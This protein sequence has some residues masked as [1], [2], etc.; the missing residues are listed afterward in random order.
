MQKTTILFTLLVLSVV[1]AGCSPGKKLTTPEKKDAINTM[2][3][4]TL[5][6]L[7]TEKASTKD[8]VAKAAGYAAFSNANVNIIFASAGGGYGVVV[9]NATGQKTYMKMGSGGVGLGLGAK[10][11]RQVMIFSTPESME[12]FIVSGWVFGGH[13]DAAAKAGDKG[14]EASGEGAIGKVK[15]YSLTESGLALQATVSGTKY[16]RD[17]VLSPRPGDA[18]EDDTAKDDESNEPS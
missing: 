13:A 15:V 3:D 12:K 1:L 14:G 5:Q 11:F 7:Y 16:Y 8:E 6:R 17:K 10:D 9:D 18:E 4:E 2:A